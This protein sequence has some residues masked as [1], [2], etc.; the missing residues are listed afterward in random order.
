MKFQKII[1][2]CKIW[3]FFKSC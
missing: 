1:C 2:R 3:H